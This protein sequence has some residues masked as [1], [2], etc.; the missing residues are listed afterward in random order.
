M[1]LRPSATLAAE[2]PVD[3]P[4]IEHL[5]GRR[6]LAVAAVRAAEAVRAACDQAGAT[7]GADPDLDELRL[8]PGETSLTFEYGKA[9]IRETVRQYLC[10][11]FSCGP[12]G[13]DE[14][15]ARRLILSAGLDEEPP[16]LPVYEQIE[17]PAPQDWVRFL[18]F[19][20]ADAF[21]RDDTDR[22]LDALEDLHSYAL[23]HHGDAYRAA[24]A[25]HD[26]TLEASS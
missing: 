17:V 3:A 6:E 21:V 11:R 25:E 26:P 5:A 10:S 9:S 14:A 23:A 22:F 13:P 20:R 16:Y 19:V 8:A 15:A 4:L 18:A 1:L 24:L 2:R 12:M 7:A